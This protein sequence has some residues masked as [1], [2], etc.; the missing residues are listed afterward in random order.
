MVFPCLFGH[1]SW[2][3]FPDMAARSDGKRR[4]PK[5]L[6][7]GGKFWRN[8]LM[9]FV[10]VSLLLKLRTSVQSV[11]C[12]RNGVHWKKRHWVFH[13]SQPGR[14]GLVFFGAVSMFLLHTT[15]TS[16][17]VWICK[18]DFYFLDLYVSAAGCWQS[19]ASNGMAQQDAQGT[20]PFLLKRGQVWFPQQV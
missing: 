9:I 15:W 4:Q 13:R 10:F 8:L 3:L 11:F 18:R 14:Q 17:E 16:L 20:F 6:V 7:L 12:F 2:W 19:D 1:V 5:V